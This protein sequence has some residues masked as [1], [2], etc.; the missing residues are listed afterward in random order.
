MKRVFKSDLVGWDESATRAYLYELE[1]GDYE[2]LN[3]MTHHE[4][5]SFFNVFD[6]SGYDI[7]PGEKYRIY[8]FEL[9][10]H[11]L[12]MYEVTALNI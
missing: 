9:H 12:V 4:L 5:C 7:F 8:H 3:D 1:E 11:F 10:T 2:M 6:E